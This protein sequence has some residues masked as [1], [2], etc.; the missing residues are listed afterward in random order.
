MGA[1]KS[2]QD[3]PRHLS[4]HPVFPTRFGPLDATFH[5][6]SDDVVGGGYYG[7]REGKALRGKVMCDLRERVKRSVKDGRAG[8]GSSMYGS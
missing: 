5:G 8:G 4:Q 1:S 2:L 3:V 6:G 7:G